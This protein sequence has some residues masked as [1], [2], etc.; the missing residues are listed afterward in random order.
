MFNNIYNYNFLVY[1][2]YNIINSN[3]NFSLSFPCNIGPDNIESS[4]KSY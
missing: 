1:I 4:Y 2:N 3:K